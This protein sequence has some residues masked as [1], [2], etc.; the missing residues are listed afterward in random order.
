M[1]LHSQENMSKMF[2]RLQ[3]H[4]ARVAWL[5]Y[6]LFTYSFA[7]ICLDATTFYIIL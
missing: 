7:R 6:I 3:L 2:R 1:F 4:F 5:Y